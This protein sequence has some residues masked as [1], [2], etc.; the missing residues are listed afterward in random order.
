[1]GKFPSHYF[2]LIVWKF[3]QDTGD[4]AASPPPRQSYCRMQCTLRRNFWT[5][6]NL[7]PIGKNGPNCIWSNSV[8]LR[9]LPWNQADSRSNSAVTIFVSS[10]DFSEIS[11][12]RRVKCFRKFL[13]EGGLSRLWK[14]TSQGLAPIYTPRNFSGI[15]VAFGTVYLD[16]NPSSPQT[17]K[18]L[19]ATVMNLLSYWVIGCLFSLCGCVK[20]SSV[21]FLAL[22]LCSMDP[23]LALLINCYMHNHFTVYSTE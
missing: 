16:I 9:R 5:I 13:K 23:P 19:A 14:F 21:S 12:G 10:L 20:M 4:T 8:G 15:C 11:K 22:I 7:Y 1:M 17:W 3:T 18:W 2:H 6:W